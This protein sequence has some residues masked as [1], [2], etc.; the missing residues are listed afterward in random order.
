MVNKTVGPELAEIWISK[1]LHAKWIN[2]LD[3]DSN[4]Q[5]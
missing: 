2:T 4:I 1:G 5:W 3:I